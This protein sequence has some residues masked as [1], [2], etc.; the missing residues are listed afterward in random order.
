[1]IVGVGTMVTKKKLKCL[2]CGEFNDVG[3]AKTYTGPASKRAAKKSGS[4]AIDQHD[5]NT[6]AQGAVTAEAMQAILQAANN[7][8]AVE[9]EL[10]STATPP[11]LGVGEGGPPVPPL[12]PSLPTPPPLPPA[13]PGT[14]P[15]W[16]S[17]PAG[18]NEFRYWDGAIWTEHVSTSGEQTTDP[19]VV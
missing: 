2:S 6:N 14:A 19:A 10:P 11:Q 12:P 4:A 1:M 13:A 7:V 15:S 17:D 16:Q 18:R 5:A 8:Q 3:N 9:E